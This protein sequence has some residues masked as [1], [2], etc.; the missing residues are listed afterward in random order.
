MLGNILSKL[1]GGIDQVPAV[2]H[3][4]I[5]QYTGATLQNTWTAKEVHETGNGF[6]FVDLATG[7]PITVSGSVKIT[8]VLTATVAPAID[9]AEPV[10]ATA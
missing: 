2:D 9:P 6:A 1:F 3:Y 4:E 8:G 5:K 7:S 10:A